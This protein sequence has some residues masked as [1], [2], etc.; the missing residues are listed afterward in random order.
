M[1]GAQGALEVFQSALWQLVQEN[2]ANFGAGQDVESQAQVVS[3]LFDSVRLSFLSQTVR[4]LRQRAGYVSVLGYWVHRA[5][6]TFLGFGVLAALALPLC[7]ISLMSTAAWGW[8]PGAFGIA[9]ACG[10]GAWILT[11][12][13]TG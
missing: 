6:F 9:A 10:A 3:Q 12:V 2:P 5:V 11:R 7:A 8:L 13:R 1:K 4:T